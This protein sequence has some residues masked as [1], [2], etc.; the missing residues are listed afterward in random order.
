[1]V[2]VMLV[3]VAAALVM[4][5]VMLVIVAAALIVVVMML[6]IVVV[7]MAVPHFLQHIVQHGILL[8]DNLKKLAALQ[9]IDGSGHDGGLR[10]LLPDQIHIL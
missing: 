6:V 10:I 7:L 1:M 3:I 8:L 2:V 9:M 4:V 5:V